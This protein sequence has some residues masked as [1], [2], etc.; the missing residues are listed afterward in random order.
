M[1]VRLRNP[2]REVELDGRRRVKDV[3]GELGVD[4]DSVLV[5]RDRT[6][7]TREE[8]LEPADEVGVRP[9][10]SGG[11]GS[12]GSNGSRMRC[13]RC[14]GSAVIELRRHNA[15]FCQGCFERYVRGQVERAIEDHAMF[16]A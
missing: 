5:I 15:A 11:A 12:G 6:L 1:K 4:P 9:V 13:K 14:G 16:G 8:W 7:V 2:D 3:L 10:S